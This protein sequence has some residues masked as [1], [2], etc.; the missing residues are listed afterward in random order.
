MF[1]ISFLCLFAA[2][3]LAQQPGRQIIA[4]STTLKSG[5]FV[6][7]KSILASTGLSTYDIGR[8]L[9]QG[10]ITGVADGIRREMVDSSTGLYFGYD[11]VVGAGEDKNGYLITF[12][13]P[14]EAERNSMGTALK[15]LPLPKYPPPMVVHD[16]DVIVLDLM[17]SPDGK[18]KLTDYVEILSQAPEPGAANTTAEPRDFTLDDGPVRFDAERI[19]IWINGRK[20]SGLSGF[21][22]KNGATFWIAFPDQG[23]Y[24]LSLAPHDGFVASGAIRDNVV[25]FRDGVQE[26]EVRFLSPIAGAGKAWNLHMMHDPSYEP[27]HN[28]RHIISMGT[29]RLENLRPRQ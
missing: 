8:G 5:V 21:T 9:G 23:R 27:N 28:Q 18:Q 13:P 11:L 12:R 6:R 19:A 1:G 17:V 26:Y 20:Y 10:G 14:V 7:F 22:G 25:S 3:A 29:D 15:Y 2:A 4:G 16:G 24:I